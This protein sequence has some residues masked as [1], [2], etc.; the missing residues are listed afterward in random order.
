MNFTKLALTAVASIGLLAAAPAALAIP[1]SLT[2]AKV[3]FGT[4]YGVDSSENGGTLLDVRFTDSLFVS[5]TFGLS[6]VNDSFTFDLGTVHFAEPNTGNGS[7]LGIK[8][9]EQDNL[10]VTWTFSFTNPLSNNQLISTEA[11]A[12]TGTISDLGVDYSLDWNYLDVGFGDG[13]QFRISLND[14]SFTN[15]GTRTQSAT[16]TLLAAPRLSASDVGQDVPEPASLA[17]VG[18]A[19]AGLASIRRRKQASS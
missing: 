16:I 10:G 19:L 5:R 7:N 4:G 1:F 12:F 13:G 14:L 3:S 9:N 11:T 17:L 18:L 15:V 6:E 2:D 8:S